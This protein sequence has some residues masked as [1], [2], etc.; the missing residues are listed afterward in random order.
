MRTGRFLQKRRK[1]WLGAGKMSIRRVE[2]TA[3]NQKSHIVATI[4][5]KTGMKKG[6]YAQNVPP[7]QVPVVDPS[8]STSVAGPEFFGKMEETR[9]RRDGFSRRSVRP[10]PGARNFAVRPAQFLPLLHLMNEVRGGPDPL[11]AAVA[12]SIAGNPG[13]PERVVCVLGWKPGSPERVVCVL[14]WKPGSPQHVVCV[15]RWSGRP[16]CSGRLQVAATG[17][18]P[19]SGGGAGLARGHELPGWLARRRRVRPR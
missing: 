17:N 2:V 1:P 6:V 4:W 14:G 18:A 19:R 3:L 16:L 8:E 12:A 9:R 13:S 10:A 15:P 11:V 7:D 5:P